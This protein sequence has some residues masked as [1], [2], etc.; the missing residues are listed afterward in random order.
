MEQ[1]FWQT[2]WR[3]NRIGF[4]EPA[5]NSLL[6][7][8]FDRL[9]L[10]TGQSVFVPLCGKALDLD[11]LCAQGLRVTGVEFNQGAVEDVF[12]RQG[13]APEISRQE[14]L[15][16]FQAGNLTLYAGDFF[17]LL[18][19][20]LG[21][22]DAVY[23]RAALVAVKPED[24]Q[25]YAAHLN[26]ITGTAKQLLIGFDYDQSLM[27]G[28]PFSVPGPTVQALYQGSHDINLIEERAADGRIGEHCNA[29]EQAWLLKPR[30]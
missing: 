24:R 25:A 10:I 12:A 8:Y 1:E 14:G 6:K 5:P 13:L 3:E 7:K 23:D 21:Q 15:I 30:R 22:V 4:H 27:E 11:W 17:A 28:P 26:R 20:L 9:D 16:R 29:L 18:P 2:R 19:A